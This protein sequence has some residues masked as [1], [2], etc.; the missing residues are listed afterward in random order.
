MT[1]KRTINGKSI[2]LSIFI[3]IGLASIL[4]LICASLAAIL[5]A[6]ERIGVQ[7]IRIIAIITVAISTA[8][9]AWVAS[10]L[11]KKYRT[12]ICLI[13][14]AG[15]FLILLAMTALLFGGSYEKIPITLI[16]VLTTSGLVGLT[17]IKNKNRTQKI[18][19]K[20]GYR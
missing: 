14:G 20:K 1:G 17:G 3:G 6:S 10:V 8:G 5:L 2:P 11:A 13:T 4:T 7:S 19:F 15:Y 18:R 9:G 12:Q 16:T